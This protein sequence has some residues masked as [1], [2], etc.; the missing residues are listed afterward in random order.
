MRPFLGTPRQIKGGRLALSRSVASDNAEQE[1]EAD[2]SYDP[3]GTYNRATSHGRYISPIMKRTATA[4]AD[5][6]VTAL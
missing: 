6:R 4:Y 1:R 2:E 3:S 5:H